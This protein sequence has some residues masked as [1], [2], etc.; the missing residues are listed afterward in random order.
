MSSSNGDPVQ[1]QKD[2]TKTITIKD[3]VEKLKELLRLLHDAKEKYL[4][5]KSHESIKKKQVPR[6]D[7]KAHEF[8]GPKI[9]AAQD[10]ESAKK[11][12]DPTT[13]T[14]TTTTTQLDEKKSKALDLGATAT[15]RPEDDESTKKKEDPTTT[16]TELDEKKSKARNL[17]ATATPRPEDDELTKKKELPMPTTQLEKE[18]KAAHDVDDDSTKDMHTQL[19]KVCKEIDYM[20]RSFQK[21]KNFE[22]N[23]KEPLDTLRRNVEDI[24]ED[25]S[26]N[27][28]NESVKKQLEQNL[29]VL[30]RNI[31]KVKILIPLQHQA[32]NL[33]SDSSRYLQDTVASREAGDLPNLYQARNILE[34]DFLNEIKVK[35]DALNDDRLKLCLLCFAIF[36][37]NAEVRK[38]LLRFWWVGERLTEDPEG[39]TDHP[40]H[41][42]QPEDQKEKGDQME[43][44]V[45]EILQTLARVGFIEPVKKQSRLPATSYTMHP[46]VRA[47][48][49]RL[50]KEAK[51][52]D[53]DPKGN[54]ATDINSAFRSKKT[55]LMKE[56]RWLFK[57]SATNDQQQKMNSSE[58]QQPQKSAQQKKKDLEEQK[59]QDK[60]QDSL[61]KYLENLQTVFNICKQFVDLP[62]EE[63]SKMKHLLVLYLGRW[64]RVAE[65]HMEIENT[66]FLRGLENM[67]KLRLFS[68]QGISGI[69]ELPPSVSKLS[70]LRML[71]LRACHNLEKLAQGPKMNSL[72][73]R[74]KGIKDL[75]SLKKLA[76]LDISE[77]YL[78]DTMPKQLAELSE[79]KVLKGFVISKD[80]HSC[81]LE[82]LI[83][84]KKLMKLTI[85][86]S[87][88]AFKK[89]EDWEVFS[90]F[91]ALQKLRIAWGAGS[92]EEQSKFEEPKSNNKTSNVEKKGNGNKE[93]KR[94][95]T[96]HAAKSGPK[97][98]MPWGH[99]G[100]E[101]SKSAHEENKIAAI[102]S[103]KSMKDN[104]KRSGTA[105]GKENVQ[106]MPRIRLLQKLDLQCFPNP[107]PPSR[108]V[109][110]VLPSLKSL[111]IRGGKL[112]Y[113]GN[114]PASD[115]DK[116]W[117]VE[118]LR[119]KYLGG[120]QI[121]WKDLQTQFPELKYLE[122]VNCPGITFCPCDANGVWHKESLKQN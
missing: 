10:D 30:R 114:I 25:L 121:S 9:I 40:P 2:S 51:F 41:Q 113:L 21:L 59:S 36:P 104:G 98:K 61:N 55:C 85:N 11:K 108:L 4:E 31:T 100:G 49:I 6:K 38:S 37:E 12:E 115:D 92:H 54:P 118:F 101:S 94:Q 3:I 82:S 83:A 71:D 57:K 102:Q 7:S 18:S 26:R 35:Y 15:P 13:T 24:K 47:V 67:K 95:Q 72:M 1:Q 50:A 80:K 56:N 65:R 122:K 23:L 103:S 70:N 53:Y 93:T 77:C 76:Y 45:N 68:L 8:G 91:E 73:K 116:K 74:A 120:V 111:Y 22:D 90:R 27:T 5:K 39:L 33:I 96:Y 119:L 75:S 99:C 78:L 79:L 43:N 16:T 46:I 52:F 105:P 32:S 34:S 69:K 62:E 89:D 110:D 87:N 107:D 20:I 17:G 106:D 109:P 66:D 88:N 117:K 60:Y 19:E 63:F 42:P 58:T 14:T 64:E 97:L 112:S 29:K 44:R 48:V 28:T 81:T 84:L 86:V